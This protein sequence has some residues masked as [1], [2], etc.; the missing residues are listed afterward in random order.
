MTEVSVT[1]LLGSFADSGG[2][3]NGSL[4]SCLRKMSP[5][6][7]KP[8]WVAVRWGAAAQAVPTLENLHTLC[9]DNAGLLLPNGEFLGMNVDA[10]HRLI[11]IAPDGC[12]GLLSPAFV[13]RI[14]VVCSDAAALSFNCTDAFGVK[15]SIA[16]FP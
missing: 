8:L 2:W 14:T 13:S 16:K 1:Q 6:A 15:D 5:S 11:I 9:D 7:D 4:S 10:G 12:L 3:V